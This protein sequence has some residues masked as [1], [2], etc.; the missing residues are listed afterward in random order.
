M[1]NTIL[2]IVD[3]TTFNFHH[4]QIKD[5][6]RADASITLKPKKIREQ[7]PEKV[8]KGRRITGGGG[9]RIEERAAYL[10]QFPQASNAKVIL[11]TSTHRYKTSILNFPHFFH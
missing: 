11:L 9:K 7:M 3:T 5:N 4:T 2:I 8:G 1:R 6:K 10:F